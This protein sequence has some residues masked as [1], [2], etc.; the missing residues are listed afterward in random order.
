MNCLCRRQRFSMTFARIGCFMAGCCYGVEVPWGV[1]FPEGSLAP[2]WVPLF[3]SQLAESAGHLL[4]FFLFLSVKDKLRKK[5]DLLFLYLGRYA[6]M[7]FILEYFRGDAERGYWNGLSTSQ[8][9]S[10]LLMLVVVIYIFRNLYAEKVQ[11]VRVR[12]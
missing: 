8:W 10:L 6:V 4:L 2:A 5:Q 7:R 3:P 12:Q 1:V 11:K 9:I